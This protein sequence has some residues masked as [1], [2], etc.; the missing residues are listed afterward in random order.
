M[1]AKFLGVVLAL[2]LMYRLLALLALG[3]GFLLLLR[4]DLGRSRRARFRTL[5]R[6]LLELIAAAVHFLLRQ[7]R[8]A[9]AGDRKCHD[10]SKHDSLQLG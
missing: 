4:I 2:G 7:R 9:A 5:A 8:A 3:R 6:P 10:Q 1:S